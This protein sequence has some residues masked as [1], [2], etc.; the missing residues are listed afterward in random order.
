ME[1]RQGWLARFFDAAGGG[2]DPELSAFGTFGSLGGGNLPSREECRE[3]IKQAIVQTAE[4]GA[5]VI[6]AHATAH[7]LAGREGVLRLFVTASPPARA[8]RLAKARGLDEQ[9]AIKKVE[10]SNDARADYLRRFYNVQHELPTHYDLVI[11]TDK[12]SIDQAASII[13]HAAESTPSPAAERAKPE[14]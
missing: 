7:A 9:A 4:Q 10:E 5:V 3:L 11:N 13:C 2:A 14:P 8:S 6:I 1:Q 12:L